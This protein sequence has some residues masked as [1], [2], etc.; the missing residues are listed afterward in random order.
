[1]KE[2]NRQYFE[3][4]LN[5]VG[6]IIWE[7]DFKTS[8]LSFVSHHVEDLL[9]YPLEK[10]LNDPG[11]FVEICHPDDLPRVQAAKENVS[12]ENPRYEVIY[13]MRHAD[14]RWVWLSDR[15]TVAFEN[16]VPGIIRAVSSDVSERRRIE[17]ALA[18]VVEVI[19]EASEL[20]N[21]EEI[22]AVCT[23]KICQLTGFQMGFVWLPDGEKRTLICS[24][25]AFYSNNLNCPV[26]Q[27][28][29]SIMLD[30]GEGPAGRAALS[31]KPVLASR[32]DLA[33]D[34]R[35]SLRGDV[36]V[37]SGFAFPVRNGAKLF[38]V[39]EFFGGDL[40][41]DKYFLDAIEEIGTHLAVVFERRQAQELL[42]LQRME[43]Q[44]ILDSVPAIVFYKDC[45]NRILRAN[46]AAANLCGRTV[47]ELEGRMVSE[48]YP[49]EAHLYYADDLEVIATGQPK[50]GIIEPISTHSGELGWLCTDKIP[51]RDASGNICGVIVFAAD[52][53]QLKRTEADLKAAQAELES[54]VE[55]RTKELNQANM[56]FNLSR[57]MLCIASA[58]GD[59]KRVNSAWTEKLGYS[60]EELMS[61]PVTAFVH[62]PDLA[63]TRS[64]LA[65][66]GGGED[67]VDFQNRYVCKDGSVRWLLWSAAINKEDGLYYAV[68]Y[69]ITDRKLA[70]FEL[71][72]INLALKNAVEGIAKLDASDRYLSVNKSYAELYGFNPEE[73]IHRSVLDNIYPEDQAKWRACRE[74]MI[75]T[76]KAEVELIGEGKNGSLFYEQITLVRTV[77]EDNR[78]TGYYIFNKDI[79]ARKEVE[80]RLRHSET[81]FNQLAS[82]VPG[83]IYQYLQSRDGI[84]SFPYVSASCKSILEV[85]PEDMMSDP[86]VIFKRI[87]PDDL[88]DLWA[89]I[90]EAAAVPT[91]FEWEG[92]L[93]TAD[94]GIKWIRAASTPEVLDNGDMLF[95]GLVTDISE[96]RRADE[97]I[98]N[99][100]R[101]LRERVEKLAS[102]NRELESLT[103]KLELAYDAALEA[104]KLKSE[105]VANIS[106]EIRTPISAVIGMSELLLDTPLDSEQKQFAGLVKDSAESLLTIINDILDFSK[107]EAGRVEIDIVPFNVLNLVEDCAELMGP[108]A[109]KKGLTLLT[110]VDPRL[111]AQL[112]GDPVRIR[113]ILLNLTGNAL[114]FTRQ[115][116]VYL[117]A[118]LESLS[119]G[120]ASVR[121]S[122]SDTGIGISDEARK[123]LF[124]PFVQADGSTTRKYGGTG[125][126]LSICKLLVEIMD[127]SIDFVTKE[128]AGSSFWFSLPL[129]T[130]SEKAIKDFVVPALAPPKAGNVL[131]VTR[132]EILEEVIASYLG[133][134]GMKVELAYD[135]ESALASLSGTIP[136]DQIIC[137]L[138]DEQADL[139]EI[140]RLNTASS[141]SREDFKRIV[142]SV[143]SLKA[144][145]TGSSPG[146]LS[147]GGGFSP[148]KECC[149][150]CGFLL[151]PFRLAEL[152]QELGRTRGEHQHFA[153][154]TASEQQ[155]IAAG[156]GSSA[157]ADNVASLPGS[158]TANIFNAAP[159]DLGARTKV[160][161]A[162]DNPVLRELALRQLKRLGINADAVG[163]GR[164]A[165]S[166]AA[167]GVYGLIL[168]DCQM[169]EMDG[170]EATL[171]IRKDEAMHG[172]HIPI[173]AMT[174]SAMKGDRESCLASGMDD[175]LSK[176]V[177]QKE[178]YELL[179]KWLPLSNGEN[180][181][182]MTAPPEDS[183]PGGKG[184]QAFDA[185]Q[186][187]KNAID[188]ASLAEL[189]GEA[190]L[191]HL[192]DSFVGECQELISDLEKAIEQSNQSEIARL[193]HQLKGLAVVMTANP[194]AEVAKSIEL[195]AKQSEYVMD[196]RFDLVKN[197]FSV[198]HELILR[199]YTAA[200]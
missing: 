103:R 109:R 125:L 186:E 90:Y 62:P 77:D 43:E 30:F 74:T 156:P 71:L 83:G 179:E 13:R 34:Q 68:V 44:I 10:W 58:Q 134:V 49:E 174:A 138:A 38:A 28:S 51:Y 86:Q 80:A 192:L 1:M 191:K 106:H 163:N 142:D 72:D 133:V 78:F 160:L 114:K 198:V 100:N 147:I 180:Q 45:N 22:A 12:L 31:A 40:A 48:L 6:A 35:Q 69:D 4:L 117:K 123:R 64:C 82:H 107:V 151:K 3:T 128:G 21:I 112:Q 98:Q 111:P 36:S 158:G 94:G 5:S 139:S 115:G 25:R 195:S 196:S 146:I 135:V 76:G 187:N 20:Q 152:L 110:W 85:E 11:L 150:S 185:A 65:R 8:A 193:A 168:M 33:A 143:N 176:P 32:S 59:F 75:S 136:F 132:C 27:E 153:S 189:Y 101:N 37:R 93:L 18:L 190:D 39:F 148:P 118:D 70:E 116:E 188:F 145:A 173:I 178:L 120:K 121:F 157:A 56:F 177:G 52:I 141:S 175:Y 122:V 92:R 162:E 84:F 24:P 41:Y 79:T 165:V 144:G 119:P 181:E 61:N 16:G 15:A 184:S 55:E 29:L 194:L 113:Q 23:S 126:G 200:I 95:N 7:A 124:R 140:R 57:D 97:E 149:K 54:K 167:G 53:T 183:S 50:L 199:R 172:G 137:D 131:L 96:K 19:A 17:E 170:Y 105:F 169:P 182:D 88:P 47:E 127:G 108:A 26:H 60:A 159:K 2:L 89:T 130:A 9:G 73:M 46:R 129:E 171:S 91:E 102:V 154:Q 66:L 155:A 67:M 63:A 14:G 197:E 161:V 166:A 99:L 42:D 87:H 81:R 164:E 104:S